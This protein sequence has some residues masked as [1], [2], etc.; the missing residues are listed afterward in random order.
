MT[1]TQSEYQTQLDEILQHYR[2][3]TFSFTDAEHLLG[4]PNTADVNWDHF[5]MS[6]GKHR[7]N[8]LHE[9]K[10]LKIYT[11]GRNF[12]SVSVT[13]DQCA[14]HCEH[15]DDKYLQG[16]VPARSADEFTVAMNTIV[17]KGGV[18]ALISGGCTKDGKV[19]ILKYAS[20][21]KQ[22]K[23]EQTFYLNSHVG[24][25]NAEEAQK[26]KECG[27]D[28]VSFDLIL[29]DVA[30]QDVFHLPNTVKSYQESYEALKQAGVQVA[31]HLLIGARFG[32]LAK[33]LDVIKYLMASPPTLL[34]MIAM[35][36][37]KIHG[38][39]KPPFQNLAPQDIARIFFIARALM[40][41]TELSYGCMR[42]KGGE[43]QDTERWVI[44]AGAS[45]IEIPSQKTRKWAEKFGFSSK[46][47]GACCSISE[48]YEPFAE[49][50][51]VRGHLKNRSK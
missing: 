31:P 49:A 42:P 47:F 26:I 15:C 16:M 32:Q 13:G 6:V 41:K 48:D 51:D 33:E 18:G 2:E 50:E 36:P 43:Y 24:L 23:S 25:V 29:D 45:R 7:F 27:I 10:N 46:Y 19:P 8:T 11:P 30:I 9:A 39:I 4:I 17:D 5:F 22:F 12:V 38:Q 40:P 44:L 37:P 3:G 14:L 35:I 34:I 1:P 28:I 20:Q 21:I